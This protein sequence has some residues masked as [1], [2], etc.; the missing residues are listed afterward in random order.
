MVQRTT[1]RRQRGFTLVELMV[2]ITVIGILASMILMAMS[3]TQESA[4]ASRTRG[5]ITKLHGMIMQKY[6]SYRTVRLPLVAN[7]GPYADIA[8][9]Q[10]AGLREK[11]RMEMPDR[12]TDVTGDRSLL[13]TR[14]ALSH[15]YKR[16]Y[17]AAKATKGA[18][19]VD[20]NQSA[21]CL[22]MIVSMAIDEGTAIEGFSQSELGDVDGDTIPE[23]IDGWNKPIAF[24]RWPTGFI[25]ELQPVEVRSDPAKY[26]DFLDP[27]R[28]DPAAYSIYPLIVSA[29]PDGVFDLDMEWGRNYWVTSEFVNVYGQVSGKLEGTQQSTGQWVDNIHNHLI[30][31]R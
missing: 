28:A 5:T 10:L 7:P 16:R 8:R 1:G 29:G 12:W 26:H 27:R 9:R 14:P 18:T 15:A 22:F 13:P 21:E 6:E 11:M 17:D 30:G 25:S 4:R 2:T 24:I 19:L 23:F 20:E 3:T 31:G